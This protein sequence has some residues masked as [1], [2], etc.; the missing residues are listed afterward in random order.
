VW[1]GSRQTEDFNVALDRRDIL[2]VERIARQRGGLTLGEAVPLLELYAVKGSPKLGPAC[3]KWLA[4]LM[5][6]QP[7]V[8]VDTIITAAK[9]FERLQSGETHLATAMLREAMGAAASDEF[10]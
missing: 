3:V 1:K 9:G 5:D 8:Q 7:H 6:E 10:I 2:A 4:R